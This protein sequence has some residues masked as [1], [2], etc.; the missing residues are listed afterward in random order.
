M[1]P[2]D[3]MKTTSVFARLVAAIVTNSQLLGADEPTAQNSFTVKLLAAAGKAIHETNP[4]ARVL[5]LNM[6]FCDALW[7]EKILQRVPF[8]CF[9]IICFHP[10]RNPNAPEDKFDWWVLDQ[11]VK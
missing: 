1:L 3:V 7:T 5:G 10:Y 8:D 9:D 2:A 4:N 6:A 11:Y